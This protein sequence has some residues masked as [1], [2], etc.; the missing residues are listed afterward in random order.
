M[1]TI[2]I[3]EDDTLLANALSE[4]LSEAG[5][6]VLTAADGEKAK[7]ILQNQP[8]NLVFLDIMLPGENGYDILNWIRSQEKI[9]TLPVVMLTNLG[10]MNEI[11]QAMEAGAT[12]YIIKSNIDMEKIA[13]L[14]KTKYLPS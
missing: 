10:Q 3:V 13:T 4:T 14:T 2:L 9:M 12:D 6:S 7:A 8:V 5:Y 1:N 11:N